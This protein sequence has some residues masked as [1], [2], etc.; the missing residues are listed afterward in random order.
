LIEQS[1]NEVL[2]AAEGFRH[3]GV[4]TYSVSSRF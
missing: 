3:P 2:K 1:L 4:R